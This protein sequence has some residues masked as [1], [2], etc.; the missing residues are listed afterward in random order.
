MLNAQNQRRASVTPCAAL[1]FIDHH[2]VIT[3][4]AGIAGASIP[5]TVVIMF[6][7][8]AAGNGENDVARSGVVDEVVE[9]P[10]RGAAGV[11]SET[12]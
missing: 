1:P 10:G 12:T 4:T 6:S 8:A 7:E 5:G 9:G 11:P 2:C 3:G